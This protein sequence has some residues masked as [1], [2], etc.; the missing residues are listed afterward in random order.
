MNFE[1]TELLNTGLEKA[2]DTFDKLKSNEDINVVLDE[3]GWD[4]E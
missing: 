2:A 3:L 4:N 1:L